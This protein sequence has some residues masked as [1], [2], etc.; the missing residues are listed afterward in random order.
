MLHF[1]LYIKTK[2][3]KNMKLVLKTDSSINAMNVAIINEARAD[4]NASKFLAEG[5]LILVFDNIKVGEHYAETLSKHT[6]ITKV[7]V[8]N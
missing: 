6:T 3:N 2:I 8:L 4:A 7:Y 1:L 5:E